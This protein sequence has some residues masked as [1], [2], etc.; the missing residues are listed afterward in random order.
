MQIELHKLELIFL[1]STTY[2]LSQAPIDQLLLEARIRGL[3]ARLEDI[4]S[5][6]RRCV[7]HLRRRHDIRTVDERANGRLAAAERVCTSLSTQQAELERNEPGLRKKLFF[8]DSMNVSDSELNHVSV[9]RAT[10]CEFRF[11]APRTL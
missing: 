2:I 6:R 1:L 10:T 3:A 8:S 7:N 4:S 9:L 5:A 11:Q